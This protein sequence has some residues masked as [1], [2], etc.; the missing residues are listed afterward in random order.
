[1]SNRPTLLLVDGSSYLYRAYHAMGQ[2]L[3]APDGAPTGALYGVLN[4]LRRLRSE[5]PH[6]YCAVV[7]DAKGKN[8]RHQM[9]E[10]YKA[11]RP[12][13]PDDLRPQAEALP[14]LVRLTGWPVLVIGQVEADD[15]I[16][17]LAKQGAEHGLRVIVSTGDK[18]M[19]QLVDE[20]VTLVNTM[21]GETLDIEGVKAKFGVRPDQ[22]RDYLALMG[23]KVDNVP[24]VEKCGP[25][26]AVKWLEAYGSLQGVIEHASEI[27][28]KVGENLQAA[29]PQLPL[30]YDL[31]TIKT[32]VDLHAELSDGIESLRRTAPKWAQLVVDF[33]RWGFRTWLKEAESNMNTGS[34]DDLFGSDSI[35]EQAALNAEMPFEK[36]AEKAT[37]PEKLDYQAVTTEAQFAALLDKLSRADTIGIDTETTSLDA[38]NASLVGISIAF[39]AGEAVYI[40]VGH[41]LTAA[42]E[43]LDLQDVLGRLKPHL[44]NPALKKIGQN[45]KYDQHVFANYGIALNGIAGDAMLASYIIESHLGHGLDEL[46]ERWLGLETITYESLC[47]KG[48]KQ[49]SFAD[50][51]IGQATEYAAQDADFALRLEAHLRAQMDEKQLEM[52]E[53]MELPVAQ[54]LFEMERNGVQIDRAELA[55]QSAELG[56]E[57]MKLEQQAY[58][59]ADQPFNLN[60]PKQLQ[61]ILFDKMGI[62][63][64]GLKKTAKGGISTNEAVL[65]Q[66]APDYPLPKIILQ[67]RSL[68]KLKSTYTDKL[69]EMI[70]PKDGRVHTTYAQAVAI[71]GR[72]ASNNPNL[73]NIPIRTAE[74]RRVRRA[75]TAPQGSVIVSADYS[76]IELR[77]MAHLSGDKT[78]IAAFQNGEDVHRRTAAE[79]FGTAPENVSSEQRRYAKT[80]N[81]GLIYGMGQYGLAKSLGIDNLSAK[82]FIDRYFARYPGVAEYMQ[83]T[84]EQAAA[85]GYVET[86]FGRRLYL[87]DI[88]N[89]NANARAGA[90][91]A[92]INAPMQG[93]ASDLIKRAMI[94]V[95]NCLSDGIGS[96]LVMQVHDEL[97]LEVVETELDFVKEKLPQIMAK[98]DGGLLD[99]PLV[100][101]VGVG[102]NWEEAH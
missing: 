80:I 24:G 35:G 40:P 94:D 77:I 78:L 102:E 42:P 71:T 59:A 61:E 7:F 47:G 65:E 63:T 29:L 96:K 14:D 2:N 27:K 86:L 4:M 32:D 91:R 5:Y 44:E 81:F 72:L 9:F 3:T 37:A 73:Q 52:Y 46:S 54:V 75:F 48:A 6:D 53:K 67:N 26:T 11:T 51:A 89:K 1:M 84:K 97:V 28:G 50:V 10:E 20:R 95:R 31:V 60:S 92:A 23:D 85:Q 33:K 56:A 13:M 45:L 55:R 62:P 22:I 15:V 76:Q 66:L 12:P 38:M 58:A 49:I 36:Q 34:T 18:D 43:Q 101:E 68:A 87:P 100:A 93:T 21:S 83:R 70:S 69:P 8:F 90:E 82:N 57:L 99:V 74:G 98:V 41:S 16:G 17:T 64:K 25:K 79:V 88:R 19:A 39:Q 30:S